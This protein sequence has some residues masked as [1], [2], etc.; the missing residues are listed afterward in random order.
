MDMGEWAIQRSTSLA[1]GSEQTL[2]AVLGG[3]SNDRKLVVSA[4]TPFDF[5]GSV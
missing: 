3:F 1:K 4:V 5:D 2:L